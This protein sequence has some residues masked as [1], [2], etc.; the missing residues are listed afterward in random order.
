M[1]TSVGE[2]RVT[3]LSRDAAQALTPWRGR[4]VSRHNRLRKDYA[5]ATRAR[6]SAELP[7]IL[8]PAL[9]NA[10]AFPRWYAYDTTCRLN[11]GDP[12]QLSSY[13][14]KVSKHDVDYA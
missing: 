3:E 8:R 11:P 10:I 2:G 12:R 9:P 13:K 6:H 1:E 7:A 4:G 14:W 5:F